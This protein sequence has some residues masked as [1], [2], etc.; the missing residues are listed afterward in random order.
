MKKEVFLQLVRS[1]IEKNDTG[2]PAILLESQMDGHPSNRYSIYAADPVVILTAFGDHIRLEVNGDI[3]T[4]RQNPWDALK[5][6]RTAC[7]GWYLGYFG[8][9][10]K[11]YTED[12]D[13]AND[14]PAGAPDLLFFKPGTLLI[15]DHRTETLSSDTGP[16]PYSEF[17]QQELNAVRPSPPADTRL[18]EFGSDTGRETYLQRILEA[19]QMIREGD[20]YEV[21]LSHLLRGRFSGS[22]LDLY[23]KM[24]Q[25]GP[26]PF[27]AYMQWDN[28]TVCSASPERFL[29]REGRRVFSQPIKGTAARQ[30]NRLDDEEVKRRL[31]RSEKE[32]AENLM[33]VDLVRHDLS[34]ISRPGT[35]NVPELFSLQSFETVHQLI[36]TIEG[37]VIEGIDPVDIVKACFPMGSM[38]GAPKIRAM[39]AIEDL[40]DYRR[41]IYSGAAGYIR[42]DGDFDFNVVIRTAILKKGQLFYPV[43]GA[44]TSDSDPEKE[45]EETYI[46]ARALTGVMDMP[47]LLK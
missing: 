18:E 7:P 35:I 31:L 5:E 12:L 6:V 23:E 2:T 47:A 10:L 44:I 16:S 43:G 14:D 29:G 25:K 37:E 45:W 46:K 38:T 41:G 4:R 22:G 34:K 20:F 13:S 30:E 3:T 33:I 40:E 36:S 21:N 17:T 39:K 19:Q 27:A 9:D 24:K 42:P 26:V 1:L 11:N 15:Y 28:F 32:R 8:Y